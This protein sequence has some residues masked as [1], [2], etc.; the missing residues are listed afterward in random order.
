LEDP[1]KTQDDE[2]V[3]QSTDMPVRVVAGEDA[4]ESDTKELK[5]WNDMRAFVLTAIE[6]AHCIWSDNRHKMMIAEY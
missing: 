5:E 1:Q 6:C 3:R 2:Q 4:G